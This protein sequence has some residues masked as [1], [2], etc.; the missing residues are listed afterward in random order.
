[1]FFPTIQ[2]FSQNNTNENIEK[3]TLLLNQYNLLNNNYIFNTELKK[4]TYNA[5]SPLK[6]QELDTC[7]KELKKLILHNN[8]YNNFLKRVETK[9][10]N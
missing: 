1:M 10:S 3:Y 9:T 6:K 4:F 5:M 8:I 2:E 7:K